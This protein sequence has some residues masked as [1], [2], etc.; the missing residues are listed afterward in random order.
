MPCL[1]DPNP[2]AAPRR[3]KSLWARSAAWIQN[4]AGTRG[5]RRGR[6]RGLRHRIEELD[7]QDRALADLAAAV[8]EKFLALG[9]SLQEQAALSGRLVQQGRTLLELAAG[10]GPGGDPVRS[11][12][13]LIGRTLDFTDESSRQIEALLVRLDQYH[14]QTGRLLQ[15]EQRVE[16][17]LAPLRIIQTLFRI[18]SAV[19]S[20][21]VQTA[22]AT[23]SGEIPKYDTR[24]REVFA[25]HAEVLT[26][27]RSSI[28]K[29]T[30]RLRRG[31]AL[32][33]QEIATTRQRI[34]AA[35]AGLARELDEGRARD[36]HLSGILGE[37]DRE[38]GDVVVSLQYQDITRQK[39]DHVQAS[40]REMIDRARP[41]APRS[42]ANL[43]Y[44]HQSCRLEALQAAAIAEELNTARS[45]IATG[46]RGILGRLQQIENECWPR[47]ELA[48]AATAV[49]A[50]VEILQAAIRDA[51]TLVPQALGRAG[52]AV[53]L[54]QSFRSVA[55]SVAATAGEMAEGMRLIA[56]NAQVQ[57]AQAG[58]SG[59]GLLILS[60]RTY[61][62]SREIK[63][64]AGE[65]GAEFS[66]A[67][68]QLDETVTQGET[69]QREALGEQQKLTEALQAV[70]PRLQAYRRTTT[71]TLGELA[72]LLPAV[73]RQASDMLHAV[74][75]DDAWG[76]P[77]ERLRQHLTGISSCVETFAG[78]RRLAPEATDDLAHLQHRYTMESEREIYEAA[79]TGSPAATGETKVSGR[80]TAT[81]PAADNVELF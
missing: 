70:E 51:G 15:E 48:Q 14:E 31:A 56:L 41:D 11:A 12:L 40:L 22:F 67:A 45:G 9:G 7:T 68:R 27:A 4:R 26:A 28:E 21:D 30:I 38:A 78:F 61:Q 33:A 46:V 34:R 66:E 10:T 43:A 19:L 60:E 24:V 37:I 16:R 25:R 13:E 62:I 73:G 8:Q 49:N 79:R 20:A 81:A 50:R 2:S 47:S 55:A 54:L 17:I 80:P 77:L 64:V 72:N 57:S 76:E 44:L 58:E 63:L 74:D 3:R 59:A 39:M 75:S 42:S 35:L 29:T 71:A 18:E 52:E 36:A 69:L 23:L 5:F 32:H 1:T 53:A 6:G 65:I